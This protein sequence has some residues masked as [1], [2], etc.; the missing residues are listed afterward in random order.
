MNI[1]ATNMKLIAIKLNDQTD[2]KI[3][4]S[5]SDFTFTEIDEPT[6][7]RKPANPSESS[8][9]KRQKITVPHSIPEMIKLI[10]NP[11]ITLE[12]IKNIGRTLQEMDKSESRKTSIKITGK[13]V[14]ILKIVTKEL[15]KRAESITS[16]LESSS[17]NLISVQT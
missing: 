15:K 2:F 10:E 12:S 4:I 8:K 16:G 7:K 14:E 17:S 6:K 3:P 1:T 9:E 13:K 11:T 5:L